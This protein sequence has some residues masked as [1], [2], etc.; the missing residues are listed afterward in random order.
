MKLEQLKGIFIESKE[1][2]DETYGY[3]TLIGRYTYCKYKVIKQLQYATTLFV[4]VDRTDI[5]NQ[6]YD[7]Y[8]NIL[9]F[10]KMLEN[11]KSESS[12]IEL[13]NCIKQDIIGQLQ[14]YSIDNPILKPYID[15]IIYKCLDRSQKPIKTQNT[16]GP[17]ETITKGLYLQI[18]N[19]YIKQL[20]DLAEELFK[21][22]DLALNG[23]LI[24]CSEKQ[25]DL[26]S[27]TNDPDW[28]SDMCGKIKNEIE[29]YLYIDIVSNLL[30]TSKQLGLNTRV[31]MFKLTTEFQKR[32]PL[33]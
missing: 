31:A 26:M 29:E 27:K 23:I 11:I 16:K 22:D 17:I 19:N 15:K 2:C 4:P 14:K 20:S 33:Q 28:T 1:L 12:P 5:V 8:A 7:E 25:L 6:I 3:G 24:T 32:Y 13:E 9:R 21:S 30:N 18:L 10:M